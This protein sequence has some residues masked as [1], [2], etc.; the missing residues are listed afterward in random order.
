MLSLIK[1]SFVFSYLFNLFRFVNFLI[2]QPRIEKIREIFV[3][4]ASAVV[5]RNI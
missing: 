5:P 3:G 1:E 4:G 2:M